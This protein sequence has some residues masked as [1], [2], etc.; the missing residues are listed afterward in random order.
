MLTLRSRPL[1]TIVI[2][3]ALRRP[4]TSDSAL[5]C[6]PA[7]SEYWF[8]RREASVG[9]ADAAMALA[10]RASEA[11]RE[12]ASIVRRIVMEVSFRVPP[13]CVA[14]PPRISR[15]APKVD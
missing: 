11:A 3:A 14:P 12:A 10:A 4:A 1:V 9:G 15:L 5:E 6:P 8:E 2:G 13:L 7:H